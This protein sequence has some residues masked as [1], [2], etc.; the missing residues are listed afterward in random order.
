MNGKLLFVFLSF[1][2][3]TSSFSQ[4]RR[5][6]LLNQGLNKAY[7]LEFKAAEELYSKVID[8][9]P[10]LPDGY[11][12]IAQLYF[13]SFLASH[14]IGQYYVFLKFAELTEDKLDLLLSN[15]PESDYYTYMSGNLASL[16]A[17]AYAINN[18]AVDAFWYSKKAV[19]LF[20]RTLE[21]NPKFYDAYLGLGLFDYAMS[22]IPEFLG[23]TLNLTGLSSDKARGLRY[24]K[25]AYEKGKYDKT[26]AAFHLSKIYVDYIAEYDSAEIYINK[27][28]E[29][30]SGNSLFV[31][32]QGLIQFKKHKLD[33][34]L[35]LFNK[36]IKINKEEF[37]QISALARYRIANIYFCKNDFDNALEYY[38]IFYDTAREPDYLSETALK[39]ALCFKF[40]G[41]DDSFYVSLERIDEGNPDLFE[42]AYAK[43]LASYL[44]DTGVT[45]KDLLL[46]RMSNNVCAARF[47]PVYDTLSVYADSLTGVKKAFAL[48][49]L[50]EAAFN[51][52]KYDESIYYAE[53]IHKIKFN[54][55]FWIVPKSYFLTAASYYSQKNYEKALH[56][57]TLAED[58]NKY[59]FIDYLQ[60]SIENLKRKINK[61]IN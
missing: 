13:W 57:L 7:N 16:R 27:L 3:F 17:M 9:E 30:Y 59:D 32:Q 50:S 8:A 47:K 26:E 11:Y 19:N 22:F 2:F 52:K 37:P 53:N 38:K 5:E 4:S 41:K 40:L 18:S 46:I 10:N 15:K 55:F 60:A 21:I 56:Y 34:A 42:D 31:Y 43:K 45:D 28:V 14:D 61:K 39:S 29:K 25:L 51:L 24:V 33:N 20:N 1:L 23:W 35:S 49:Y 44:K 54:K 6:Y 58:N 12:R 48:L 36:V